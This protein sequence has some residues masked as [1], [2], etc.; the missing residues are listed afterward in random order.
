MKAKMKRK[1]VVTLVILGLSGLSLYAQNGPISPLAFDGH[2]IG[3]NRATAM[4]IE[5]AKC[6]ADLVANILDDK[7]ATRKL[8]QY[9]LAELNPPNLTMA[10][11]VFKS[12]KLI[13]FSRHESGGGNTLATT[14]FKAFGKPSRQTRKTMENA[15]G[16]TWTVIVANWELPNGSVEFSQADGPYASSS[17]YIKGRE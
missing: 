13:S 10:G 3:E 2:T 4:A 17:T 6:K 14:T 12:D 16:A 7:E 11:W 8:Y 5:K 9:C 15:F 1:L